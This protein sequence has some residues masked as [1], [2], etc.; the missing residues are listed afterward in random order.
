[1]RLAAPDREG[2]ER[3]FRYG[4]RPPFALEHFSELAD[5]RVAYRLKVPNRRGETHRVMTPVECLARLCALVPP[6]WQPWVRFHGVFAP[7][8][9]WRPLV[10]LALAVISAS[11]PACRRPS[12]PSLFPRAP[13]LPREDDDLLS[14]PR[15]PR[16]RPS[17]R[18]PRATNDARL[19]WATLLARTFARDALECPRC[20][21]RLR[22][23]GTE[24]HLAL[25]REKSAPAMAA[26]KAY[27]EE[28]RPK[29]PPKGPMGQAVAY[30]LAN[31]EPLTVFL[32]DPR[33]PPDNNAS[34]GALRIVALGRA[35]YLFVG[36]EDAGKNLCSLLTLVRS[37]ERCGVNPLAYL[38]DVLVRVQ[39]HPA[40]DLDALLPD[41][42]RPR[43]PP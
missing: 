16:T 12:Q 43:A 39:S 3:L 19:D 20:L 17:P 14:P 6:P 9:A 11:A 2:R 23:L 34:E 22:L 33:V 37:A 31:W 42:W 13:F 1:M 30:A 21:G 25:R 24:A 5:G 35:N 32:N 28:E 7:N 41:R 15:A 10:V 38:T 4:A 8:H 18:A 40:S 36:H 26:L 29:H 27:L